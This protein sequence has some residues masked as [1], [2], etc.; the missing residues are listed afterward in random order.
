MEKFFK[1][2]KPDNGLSEYCEECRKEAKERANS[3][4][5]SRQ[6]YISLGVAIATIFVSLIIAIFLR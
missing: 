4:K 5:V 1:D 3:K 6:Y 2:N